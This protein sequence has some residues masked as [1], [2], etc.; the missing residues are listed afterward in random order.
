[1]STAVPPSLRTWFLVHC[2]IDVLVAVPL[3]VAPRALL[4]LLGWTEVDPAMSR[5]VAAAL[6]GIGLQSALG[7]GASVEVYRAML[8][9]MVIW[10]GA[11]VV[12]IA[13]SRIG[14]APPMAALFLVV[15]VV[16]SAIWWR[17]RL[18]LARA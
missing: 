15:F 6:L 17:Y 14:G 13:V 5:V 11:A 9:L 8:T 18:Q 7:R 4:T 10:S 2:V 12:G 16:F 1:M 3:F